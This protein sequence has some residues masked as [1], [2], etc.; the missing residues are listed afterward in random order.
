MKVTKATLSSRPGT[1]PAISSC[2]IEMPARLPSS[3]V[4]AEG[5]ISMSTPPIAMI[6]PIASFGS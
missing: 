4:R 2:E 5:G 3:T 1:M 6:G